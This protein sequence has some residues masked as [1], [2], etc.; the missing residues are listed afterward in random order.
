[1]KILLNAQ[2]YS[3]GEVFALQGQY[4]IIKDGVAYRNDFLSVVVFLIVFLIGLIV[5]SEFKQSN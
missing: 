3:D 2:G 1:M 4:Y 5:P